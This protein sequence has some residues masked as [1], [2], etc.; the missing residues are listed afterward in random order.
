MQKTLWIS[1]LRAFITVLVVA[2]HAMLAYTTFAYFDAGTYINS[3]N[4]VVDTH[5]WIGLDILVSFN[6]LFFMALMFFI[7]GL[8][9]VP[10]FIK[11]GRS[12]FLAD[13]LKRLGVPF[14]VSVTLIIPIA[15]IPSYCLATGSFSLIPFIKDYITHQGWPVGPPWFIWV[16]LVFNSI[17]V[18]MPAAFYQKTSQYL[19]SLAKKPFAFIVVVL[20]VSVFAYV[21]L[22]I[23]TGH[24]TWMGFGPFDF[25]LNRVA[26]Y[27]IWFMLGAI[28]GMGNWQRILF[29]QKKLLGM[30]APA[31]VFI[32]IAAFLT[33]QCLT[34]FGESIVT[35]IPLTKMAA[36]GIYG[37]FMMLSCLCS[38]LA[39][40]AIFKKRV[41]K[42]LP[43]M[44]NLGNNAYAIYLLHYPFISWGQYILL[45]AN[46]P[47]AAKAALVF[48]FSLGMSWL[49]ARFIPARWK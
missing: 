47:A 2:H 35:A 26:L 15:Y 11:K 30:A 8:F 40:I 36:S 20:L 39:F 21:P 28:L 25:Q 44:D 46:L 32:C 7:S 13:R 17:A 38:S 14:A 41:G 16:L 31:W 42:P 9:V 49:L 43:L 3:T 37:F 27:F 33:E 12:R 4:P 5:R 29:R 6:D 19:Y 23:A 45:G 24:Y 18:V 10:S 34:Y 22:S 1:Y 48:G